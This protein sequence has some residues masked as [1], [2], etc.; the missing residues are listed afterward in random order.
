[1]APERALAIRRSCHSMV[2]VEKPTSSPR[3][4][5]E[6]NEY[7]TK[8]RLGQQLVRRKA[9]SLCFQPTQ[10]DNLLNAW[11]YCEENFQNQ[12]SRSVQNFGKVA[13]LHGWWIG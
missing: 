13:R 6:H 9:A 1:M 7:Q 4:Q 3:N 10:L 8:Y 5:N 2:R 11:A 12:T